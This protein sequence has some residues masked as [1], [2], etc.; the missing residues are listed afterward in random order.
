[1]KIYIYY[2]KRALFATSLSVASLSALLEVVI[3]RG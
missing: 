2:S 3:S 1:M